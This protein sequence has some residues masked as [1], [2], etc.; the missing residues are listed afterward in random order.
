[1]SQT[2][3]PMKAFARR[4]CKY[5]QEYGQPSYLPNNR[6]DR[7]STRAPYDTVSIRMIRGPIAKGQPGGKISPKNLIYG[8]K[9]L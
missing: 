4:P 6:M 5:G 7:L 2:A 3:H 8:A 9:P 1:M